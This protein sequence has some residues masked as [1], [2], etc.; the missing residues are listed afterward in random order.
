MQGTRKSTL[1]GGHVEYTGIPSETCNSCHNRGK[2]IGV[3]YQ[4]I[5]ELPYG[6][7]YTAT[8]AKL[9]KLHT[10]SYL[11]IKDDLHHQAQSRP[12]NPQ[13][14]MLCQ[15]CHTTVDMHG[16]GNLFGTTLAQE[17][18][19]TGAETGVCP[20]EVNTA[21]EV[22]WA[23]MRWVHQN[24]ATRIRMPA[25]DALLATLNGAFGCP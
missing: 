21:D 9:P 24:Y 18:G 1:R 23:F 11:F 16:D 22:R 17:V 25:A 14:D 12:E 6:S 7:P 20:P 2:R 13:G 10:K 8:G 4:G 3:S 5:M 19:A 15:D